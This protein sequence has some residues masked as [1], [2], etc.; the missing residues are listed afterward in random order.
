MLPETDTPYTPPM[1]SRSTSRRRM[2]STSASML[3]SFSPSLLQVSL[4]WKVSH[5]WLLGSEPCVTLFFATPRGCVTC[6]SCHVSFLCV[7]GSEPR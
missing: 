7:A 6:T 2:L 4:P 3:M 1:S 5:T